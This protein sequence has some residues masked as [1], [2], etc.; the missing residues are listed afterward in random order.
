M[1]SPHSS[2]LKISP[3]IS[4]L[5]LIHGS[6]DFAIEV[7]RVMLNNEFDCLAVPLPPSFQ[8]NVER[9]ITFLPSITAV[10]QEEP[11]I[12]GSAPWEEDDDDD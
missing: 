5:P 2:F 9:A 12:S 11:P 3:H 4:V 1:T 7:R 8:E 10:V 6:G